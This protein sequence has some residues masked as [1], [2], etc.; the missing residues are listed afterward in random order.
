MYAR[1]TTTQ[2]SPY[3]LDEA[4]SIARER[5]V[6]AAQRQQGFKGYLM[7]VD[8]STGQG[9]TITFWEGEAERQVTG[10][11]SAYYREAIGHVVPL[12]TAQPSVQD[13][14]VVIQV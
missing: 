2:Y 14:E 4:V 7:L 8:R 13:L 12:L 1:I 5:V 3:S 6:P 11:N 10:E 9:I